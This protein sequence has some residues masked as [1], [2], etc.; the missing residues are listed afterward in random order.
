MILPRREEPVS[1]EPWNKITSGQFFTATT[2]PEESSMNNMSPMADWDDRI[3]G[4]WMQFKGKVKEQ[5]GKLTDDDFAEI[6]GKREMLEGKL[7]KLYGYHEMQSKKAV[8]DW[9]KAE[10]GT[11]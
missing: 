7:Q 8:D 9:M 6:D 5:W 2:Q 4:N 11:R 10:F 3:K 1:G